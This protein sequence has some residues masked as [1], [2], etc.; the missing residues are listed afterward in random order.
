MLYINF[1]LEP[2]V[3][4]ANAEY[5]RYA[6]PNTAVTSNPDYSLCGNEILY[7][8]DDAM[9]KTEYFHDMDSETRKIYNA[10]WEEVVNEG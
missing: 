8:A 4:L 2:E 7:P 6:S 5:I 3:A 9:P 10:L 1:L